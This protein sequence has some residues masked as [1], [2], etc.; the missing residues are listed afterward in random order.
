[1]SLGTAC[2]GLAPDETGGESEGAPLH[3]QLGLSASERFFV[4][5]PTPAAVQQIAALIKQHDLKNAARLTALVTTPQAVWLTGG[6]PEEVEK[7]VKKTMARAALERRTPV[8]VAYNIPYRDCSQ[9]SSG[10]A[11]DTAAYQAWIDGV[12][13]GIG[14]RRA[15]VI[16]EPDG[17]GII[18]YNT[19]I[20]GAT[21][22]CQP[23]VPGPDGAPV[24]APGASPEARYAQLRYAAAKLRELAPAAAVYLDGTHSSWL[25]VGE[26]AYRIDRASHD[27][28]S[29]QPLTRGFFLNT[30]NYQTTAQAAQFGTWISMCTAFATNPEEGGWRLGNFGWCASQYNP[31]TGSADYS[32]DYAA[33]VTA[34]IQGLLGNASASLPFVIDTGRNGR[35]PLD[36]AP[37]AAAP[38]G[39]PQ[40]TLDALNAGAWCNARGAGVGYR[41][42]SNT[43]NPLV[44]AYLWIKIPGQSDG[45]CDSAGGARGWDYAAYNPWGLSGDA[46][47][48]FDPLWGRVDP[49]AGVWFPEQALEL[50]QRAVPPL[51]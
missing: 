14:K 1:V 6:S 40:S 26:A 13:R 20:Y 42:T 43:G 48:H 34:Q 15:L 49:D 36:V 27:P 33:S 51:L 17:L 18:P 19:T 25:G 3:S 28:D 23:T 12:A 37:Y 41:P 4:P 16:L 22:W 2:G 35:G 47:N 8:L 30:S 24:P 9:Y 31:E 38:Y 45:A 46:T 50:A 5:P 29:G 7:S 10:G 32:A 11:L 21:E 39:Q 44:D